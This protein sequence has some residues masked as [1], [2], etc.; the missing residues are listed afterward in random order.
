M[1]INFGHL[2]GEVDAELR[3]Q[4]QYVIP[5]KG[6]SGWVF[7]RHSCGFARID[8]YEASYPTHQGALAHIEEFGL[9]HVLITSVIFFNGQEL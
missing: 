5:G 3:F 1:K 4:I 8:N 6:T 7:N 9:V 2:G